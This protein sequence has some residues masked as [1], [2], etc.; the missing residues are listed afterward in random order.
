MVVT[1]LDV[2]GGNNVDNI[3]DDTAL[4]DVVWNKNSNKCH[5]KVLM[6]VHKA[7]L[8]WPLKNRQIKVLKTNGS[9]MTLRQM[10]A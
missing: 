6:H 2:V 8:K 1:G 10:V 7:C 5:V 9:L 3:V 4:T